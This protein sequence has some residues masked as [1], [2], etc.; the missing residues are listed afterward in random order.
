VTLFQLL[1]YG[2]PSD[3]AVGTEGGSPGVLYNTPAS[4]SPGGAE[5]N[6][7]YFSLGR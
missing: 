3:V 5:G 7:N 4:N 6:H 2:S 1:S